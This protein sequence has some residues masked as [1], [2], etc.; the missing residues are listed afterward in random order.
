MT[1]EQ[2]QRIGMC[3]AFFPNQNASP[4]LDEMLFS[5]FEMLH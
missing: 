2:N 5:P 3:I 4:T 1:V